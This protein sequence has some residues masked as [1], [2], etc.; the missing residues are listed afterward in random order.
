MKI[1][2]EVVSDKGLL[3]SNNEDMALV[4]GEL[5]R[6]NSVSFAF[7][8][9]PNI[10]FAAIVADGMGG[11][12]GGEVASEMAATSFNDFVELLP[13]DLEDNAVIVRLKKW[14][15]DVDAKI[16][17]KG[18][19]IPS[20]RNMGTTFTGLLAYGNS[21]FVMNVGDSRTYRYRY[22]CMKQLTDDHSERARL[23]DDS[24]PSNLIYNA[25]GTGTAFMDVKSMKL[26]VGDRYVIC[27]DGLS[28]LVSN[29]VIHELLEHGS[30]ARQYVQAALQAGGK[31]NVTVVTMEVISM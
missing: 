11:M 16:K 30:G 25:L 13:V 8:L 6:D 20:L 3:R 17:Q 10:P 4:F 28:D 21:L 18:D 2:Y 27:S 1:K 26:V 12:N 9:T 31:D 29:E 23:G 15:R 5:V 22:E 7:E 24:I 14:A 19:R